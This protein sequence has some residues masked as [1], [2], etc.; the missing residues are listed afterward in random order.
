MRQ[1]TPV[2]ITSYKPRYQA[3]AM[4]HWDMLDGIPPKLGPAAKEPWV[5]VGLN[6][7]GAGR[8]NGRH[9]VYRALDAN[10]TQGLMTN[11]VDGTGYGPSAAKKGTAA[12]LVSGEFHGGS[13]TMPAR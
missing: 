3:G 4:V 9:G 1:S 10:Q 7:S 11:N 13:A 6:P 5:G 2:V 8:T 12:S